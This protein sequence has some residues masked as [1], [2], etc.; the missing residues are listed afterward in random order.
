MNWKARSTDFDG[1]RRTLS[2]EWPDSA[3][4]AVLSSVDSTNSA[5]RRALEELEPH[6][7]ESRPAVFVAWQQTAGRGRGGR[8]WKSPAGAGLYASV[9]APV[10]APRALEALPLLMPVVLCRALANLGVV[11]GLKW[12]NDLVVEGRKLGGLLIEAV[13][14][15]S[16]PRAAILGL[17]INYGRPR[18]PEL[19]T[20]AIGIR[21]VLDTPPSLSTLACTL[22]VPLVEALAQEPSRDLAR[23][24]GEYRDLTVHRSGDTLTCRTP[25]EVLVGD[26][27][28]IDGRG[29]LRLSTPAGERAIGAGDLVE[30]A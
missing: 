15:G 5:A 17:G 21:D 13:S 25:G 9:L 1:F 22:L 24:A 26:F 12:P 30:S 6:D 18:S 7:L 20:S 8:S 29:F 3:S 14:S 16:S 23:W 2:S 10:T 4:L 28:G 11:C 27:L 19:E